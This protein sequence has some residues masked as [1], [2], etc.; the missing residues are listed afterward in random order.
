MFSLRWWPNFWH[1][2]W[3]NQNAWTTGRLS[4][5]FFSAREQV[6]VGGNCLWRLSLSLPC[7]PVFLHIYYCPKKIHEADVAEN[8]EEALGKRG[9]S[10]LWKDRLGTGGTVGSSRR[11][12]KILWGPNPASLSSSPLCADKPHTLNREVKKFNNLLKLPLFT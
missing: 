12:N 3:K 9:Y 1:S 10:I 4:A 8:R 2:K 5:C 7:T 11:K 6:S